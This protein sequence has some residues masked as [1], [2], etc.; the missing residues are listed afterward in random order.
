MP[1]ELCLAFSGGFQRRLFS[2]EVMGFRRLIVVGCIAFGIWFVVIG[3]KKIEEKH[4]YDLYNEYTAAFA[5]EDAKKVCDMFDDKV[6]GHFQST[7]RSMPVRPSITKSAACSSVDEFYQ[8][9]R[10]LEEATGQELYAN[11][12]YTI[13]NIEISPDKKTAT[14]NVL[15]EMRVGTENGALLDMRS[16]QTDV[17]NRNLGKV[18]FVQSNGSVSFFK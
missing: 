1:G 17:I 7:S 8:S 6:T 15:M 9:M 4:I 11:F 10:K 2:G 14:V 18:R 12:E 16:N 13:K 3:G 5:S